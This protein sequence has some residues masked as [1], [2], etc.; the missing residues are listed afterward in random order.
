[1][2]CGVDWPC[3]PIRPVLLKAHL[4]DRDEVQWHMTW[5]IPMAANELGVS[6]PAKLFRRFLGWT[7]EKDAACRVCGKAGHDFLPGVPPR[8]LSCD[9]HAIEPIHRAR[10]R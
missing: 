5:L 10:K 3:E 6:D 4:E 2:D 9:D 7:L 8:L 1:M